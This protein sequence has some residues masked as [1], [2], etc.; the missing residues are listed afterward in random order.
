MGL[1]GLRRRGREEEEKK[2]QRVTKRNLG[3]GRAIDKGRQGESQ[4]LSGEG[5]LTASMR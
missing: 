3:G 5:R 2:R 4:I 1:R